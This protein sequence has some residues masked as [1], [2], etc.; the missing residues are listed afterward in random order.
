MTT[1]AP[2]ITRRPAQPADL[3]AYGRPSTPAP[4]NVFAIVMAASNIVGPV[5]ASSNS[6]D[7]RVRPPRRLAR[8]SAPKAAAAV[9]FR[10]KPSKYDFESSRAETIDRDDCC[11]RFG[12]DTRGGSM[13]DCEDRAGFLAL[14]P[15][16]RSGSPSISFM[17]DMVKGG[18]SG[19]NGRRDAVLTKKMRRAD[20]AS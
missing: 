2:I 3:S 18:R 12:G 17:F 10:E 14:P 15:P 16:G 13:Y 1:V 7:E 20:F 4:I 5:A 8:A 11:R 6:I 9:S 19:Y